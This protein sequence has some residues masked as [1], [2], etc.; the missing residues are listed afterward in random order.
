[1]MIRRAAFGMLVPLA[2]VSALL[3]F[4]AIPVGATVGAV[5][6]FGVPT[7]QSQPFGIVSGPDKALW[8][9]EAS[10]D[11]IGRISTAGVMTEFALP[12]VGAQAHEL[13]T[14]SDHAIWFTETDAMD[15][16]T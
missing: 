9:T 15:L 7:L 16:L 12:T 10:G 4:G 2:L 8:F 1:M 13:V 14:H 3:R 11:K 6:E 5:T